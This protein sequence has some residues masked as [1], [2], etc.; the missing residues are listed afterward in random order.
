MPDGN[1]ELGG[2]KVI[3]RDGKALLEDGTL[4]GSILKMCDGVKRMY[5][6]EGVSM[7]DIV[8][9]AS[10][11]PAKQIGVYDRKGSITVG[12]DADLLLVDDDLN[13]KYTFCC[14]EIAF[15]GEI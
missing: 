14:G 8:Q 9:M 15:R 7:T 13:I 1:Y 2:Q 4:A 10:V 5:I 12:K 3:V 6:L 11:N